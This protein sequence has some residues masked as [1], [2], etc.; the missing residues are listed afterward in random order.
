MFLGRIADATCS[1]DDADDDTTHVPVGAQ[2]EPHQFLGFEEPELGSIDEAMPISGSKS[3]RD[4]VEVGA[5]P[6]SCSDR[7]LLDLFLTSAINRGGHMPRSF[8]VN[9]T[10]ETG[11]RWLAQQADS[12]IDVPIVLW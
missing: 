11:L 7:K 4:R 6:D 1:I 12:I 2:L 9:T 3:L 8:A 5:R 10:T